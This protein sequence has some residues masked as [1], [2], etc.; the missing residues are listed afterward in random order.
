MKKQETLEEDA[1]AIKTI[2]WT[3]ICVCFGMVLGMFTAKLI[4]GL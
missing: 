3:M 1:D 2:L 4:Y